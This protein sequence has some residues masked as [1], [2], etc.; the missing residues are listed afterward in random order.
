MILDEVEHSELSRYSDIFHFEDLFRNKTVLITGAKGMIGSGIIKWILYQNRYIGINS[1]IIASTRNP[2]D[3]PSYIDTSDTIRYIEYGKESECLIG[4]DIDYIIHT[5]SPTDKQFYVDHPVET[6]NVI[7]EGTK[8]ILELARDKSATVV[9]L[10]SVEVYGSID[11]DTPVKEDYVGGIDSLNPRNSYPIGKKTAEALCVGYA[12]EYGV[13]VRIARLSSVHGLFQ[14]YKETRI[15]N[16]ILY[17]I[18]DSRNFELKTDGS[19]RK[20]CTYT[21]DAISAIFT[22][23]SKG[24]KGDIYNITNP[25]LFISMRELAS[26][27]F[28]TYN[29]CCKITYCNQKQNENQFLPKLSFV[30]DVSKLESLGWKCYSDYNHI[31]NID[32]KRFGKDKR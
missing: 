2:D 27:A 15:Y 9:Y 4:S 28:C 11:S 20:S 29:S 7:T 6:I 26:W 22:I 24:H 3:K 25:L 21:L 13:D 31:Y 1:Q 30:Q 10:S 32:I 19:T 8:N 14:S 23:L 16:E 5:A 12:Q 17:C 18:L